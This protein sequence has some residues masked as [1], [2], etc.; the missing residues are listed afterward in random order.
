LISAAAGKLKWF[1]LFGNQ[2]PSSSRRSMAAML[3]IK[4]CAASPA[5]L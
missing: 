4:F 1:S 5:L 2:T 3:I